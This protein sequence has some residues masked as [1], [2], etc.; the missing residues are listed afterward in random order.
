MTTVKPNHR[1]FKHAIE[2]PGQIEAFEITPI[3]AKIGGYVSEVCVDMNAR[4][5]QGDVMAK[6]CVPEM[7]DDLKEKESLAAQAKAEMV[8]SEKIL[9]VVQAN[10]GTALAMVAGSRSRA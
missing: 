5:K 2:Q 7:E 10:L 4:V 3:Y 8:Q 1:T 9:E 6:L